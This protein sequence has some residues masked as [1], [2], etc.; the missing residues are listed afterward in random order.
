[1]ANS[2]LDAINQFVTPSLTSRIGALEGESQSAVTKGFAAAIPAVL[3]LVTSRANDQGFMNQLF[4]LAQDP[5]SSSFLDDPNRLMDQATSPTRNGGSVDRFSAM[6]VGPN[7]ARL[8]DTIARFAGVSSSAASS[9]LGTAIP[10]VLGYIGRLVWQD[11]LD[12]AGLGRRLAAEHQ[13][14]LNAVPAGLSSLV[15]RGPG[16]ATTAALNVEDVAP[17]VVSRP[18]SWAW[19]AAAIALA[20]AWGAYGL[21]NRHRVVQTT[22]EQVVQ[23]PERPVGTAG[24]YATVTLPSG[25]TLRVPPAGSEAKL[26]AAV[27]SRTPVSRDTWFEFDRLAFEPES[28]RLTADS[29]AELAGIA[30]ILDAYPAVHL[31]IGGYTDNTGDPTTNLTLSRERATAVRDALITM[32]IAAD[33]LEAEGYG[34]KDPIASN[35][36][37]EGRAQNRRVAF[38]VTAP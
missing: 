18:S 36:T 13:S 3:G 34:E 14:V 30:A 5:S 9:I 17:S 38:S 25:T 12:S 7:R 11:G 23:I 1:M 22:A 10:L 2:M 24:D 37:E 19:V 31:K 20:V 16:L 15:S 29:H 4:A 21:M 32:G 35:D 28:A 33:R 8:E 6:V 26:L 27:T